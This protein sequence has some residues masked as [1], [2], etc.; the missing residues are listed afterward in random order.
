[1]RDGF[2]RIVRPRVAQ[3]SSFRRELSDH[4]TIDLADV[5]WLE[6]FDTVGL[7]F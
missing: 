2:G 3:L 1:M 7:E 5:G 6:L 4:Q